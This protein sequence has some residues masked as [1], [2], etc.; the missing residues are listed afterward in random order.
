M[1]KRK[2]ENLLKV[3]KDSKKAL[4]VDGARQVGKTY[5]LRKFADD[6]FESSVYLNFL[7][8]KSAVT[9]LSR[10]SDS[11]DFIRRLSALVDHPFIKSNTVIFL[12]EIQELTRYYDLVTTI[13][14]GAV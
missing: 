7:E 6:N 10:A 4:L 3:W 1:L 8:N 14:F 12:D 9:V 11:K 2:V 13:K 5:I